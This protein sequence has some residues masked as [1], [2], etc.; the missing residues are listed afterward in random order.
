MGKNNSYFIPLDNISIDT[1]V[2]KNL[3][4]YK[5]IKQVKDKNF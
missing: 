4:Q 5:Y 2:E 3:E 1:H